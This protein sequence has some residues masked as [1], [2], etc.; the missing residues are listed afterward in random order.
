MAPRITLEDL[1]EER[2]LV[3][4]PRELLFYPLGNTLTPTRVTY[5]RLY[6]LAK[7]RAKVIRS[8]P[9]FQEGR[10]VLLHVQDHWDTVLWF[11]SIRLAGGLPVLSTPFS[12]VDEH[13]QKH[14]RGLSDL[15]EA[16]ICITRSN[17]LSL[18]GGTSHDFQ[19]HTIEDLEEVDASRLEDDNIRS[20]DPKSLAMLMLTSGSTGNAKAVGITHH[21][22][23]ASVA[24]KTGACKLPSN[25]PFL[26]WIGLD[27][28]GAFVEIHIHALWM[29]VDQV[30]VHAANVVSSPVTFL[31]L[32]SRHQISRT[33]A[34][35][36]F[37]ASL[38][39]AMASSDALAADKHMAAALDSKSDSDSD[40]HPDLDLSNLKFLVSGGEAN[41][42]NTC[43]QASEILQ[44]YGAPKSA[45]APGF[46]MTETCAGS[47]YN[48][49]CPEYDIT[50]GNDI[51]C[52]GRCI[53][54]M[55]MRVTNPSEADGGSLRV[56][57]SGEQGDLEVHGDVVFKEYYRNSKATAEAFTADGWFRTGDRAVIDGNG[58]LRLVGRVKEVANINGVKVAL[59]DIQSALERSVQGHEVAR[60]VAFSWRSAHT[61]QIVVAYVPRKWSMGYEQVAH[62]NHLL[63]QACM[64]A[65][66][67]RPIVFALREKSLRLLPTTTLGK[68][69]RA[70]ILT[71][72]EQG[73]FEADIEEHRSIIEAVQLAKRLD[74]YNSMSQ[75]EIDPA[76][77]EIEAELLRDIVTTHGGINMIM[78][79]VNVMT[80]VWDLGF[81]SM[82]LVRLK[83][84]IDCRLGISVPT[85]LF[86]K[87][88]TARSLAIALDKH[89]RES[90]ATD[91]DDIIDGVS[92]EETATS[93]ASDYDPVVPF[94]HDGSKT[95]LWLVHPGVGEVLVF[96][97]LVQHMSD[98]DRPIYALRAR[99]FESGEPIFG[100]IDETVDTY[101]SAICQRQ[102]HG[103]YAIAGYS[104]GAMLA[105]E[106]A[107]KL[108]KGEVRF[109]GSFNLPPNIKMRMRQLNWNM[110]LLNLAYF[111]GLISE[112]QAADI[113]EEESADEEKFNA[114][115]RRTALAR[116]ERI[117]D[118]SR[119]AELGLGK[120]QL[121]AWVNVAYGLQ[122]MASDYEPSGQLDSIDIF[123]AIPLRAVA[124]S[125]EAWLRDHLSHWKHF[126]RAEPKFH[127]VEGAHYTMI[128]PDHVS[129]F[130]RTL[131]GALRARG[132]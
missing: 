9:L 68:I 128:G 105:F 101:L 90:T 110:C 7:Q 62:I 129:S 55:N 78:P 114:W 125:R 20:P 73:T 29:D 64:L 72:F 24:G 87:Y 121:A 3:S 130:A 132:V 103:P 44:R 43:I 8:I 10:P 1:L 27:H 14:I 71:L 30:H 85:I 66:S 19:L 124:D 127:A 40:G 119:L 131:K 6:T 109:L 74:E 47:I 81:T 38:C 112:E 59:A 17:L 25:R 37:L 75:N 46:G 99:G 100:S 108:P 88:P 117:A 32:L 56:A 98:E 26:N 104:Y 123:H 34:P 53:Q 61:E 39:S 16:P 93:P 102:P 115:D 79:G 95:P 91:F 41:D 89:I 2:A 120:R 82:D 15:L 13:R 113:G 77:Q 23:V 60:L 21:Q 31:E 28:V 49:Q 63:T 70:K 69:S 80:P 45:I 97:G 96:V 22:V 86:L 48:T 5:Y 118:E 126:S 57:E 50:H 83:Y 33:F 4:N 122:S 54:G 11:W 111:I 51:A 35:N 52:L 65:T 76:L 116:I 94:R 106:I 12:N 107:K 36:F 58:N 18:F 42:L 84:R 67:S 92:Q